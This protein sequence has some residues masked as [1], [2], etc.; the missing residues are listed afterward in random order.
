MAAAATADVLFCSGLEFGTLNS[1][2]KIGY[3]I[4]RIFLPIWYLRLKV[5]T[6]FSICIVKVPS[7]LYNLLYRVS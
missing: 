6:Y 7:V 1:S 2:E 5:R 4:V 3:K